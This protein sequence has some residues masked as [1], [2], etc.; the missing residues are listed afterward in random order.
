[1]TTNSVHCGDI[2]LVLGLEMPHVNFALDGCQVLLRGS[3][4]CVGFAERLALGLHLTVD[5]VELDDVQHPGAQA[6]RRIRLGRHQIRLKLR[7]LLGGG[8][9]RDEL[10]GHFFLEMK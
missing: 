9:V 3:E 5:L 6:S 1:M 7:I 2:K 10:R 8:R 4:L